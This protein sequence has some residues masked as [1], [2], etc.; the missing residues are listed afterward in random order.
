MAWPQDS[1]AD[2]LC[3]L[4]DT[5]EYAPSPV[6]GFLKVLGNGASGT[7]WLLG[8]VGGTVG[9]DAAAAAACARTAGSAGGEACCGG[10]IVCGSGELGNR[11]R[12]DR[13]CADER[14]ASRAPGSSAL[15]LGGGSWT[16]GGRFALKVSSRDEG[17]EAT[18]S[19]PRTEAELITRSRHDFIVRSFGSHFDVRNG[20]TYLMTEACMGGDLGSLLARLRRAQEGCPPPGGCRRRG[21]LPDEVAR[22]YAVCVVS[23]IGYLHEQGVMYR[24]LK[25]DNLLI[26]RGGHI[27]LTDFGLVKSLTQLRL[28]YFTRG[29]HADAATLPSAADTDRGDRGER[30]RP[31]PPQQPPPNA[32]DR[33]GQQERQA[34]YYRN[35]AVLWSTVGTPDYMAPEV[36]LETGYSQDCD[37][38][39][40]GVILYEMLVGY[41]PFYGDDPMVTCRKILC[42]QTVL[43]FPPEAGLSAEAVSLI[44]ALLSDRECRLGRRG[45][46]E[47]KAHP[48]FAKIDWSRLRE[49]GAAPFV[50]TVTSATDT[51]N[52]DSFEEPGG[53]TR[54]GPTTTRPSHVHAVPVRSRGRTRRPRSRRGARRT[55]PSSAASTAATPPPPSPSTAARRAPRRAP[56]ALPSPLLAAHPPQQTSPPRRR[57]CS[58]PT[59][60]GAARCRRQRR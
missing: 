5:D 6:A 30:G 31:P 53:R 11:C 60:P 4:E 25:P 17:G 59:P 20:K 45:A 42:F 32:W 36:L 54:H 37:W 46:D 34:A 27:K 50:P 15:A 44:R 9:G 35:R 40:L 12:G 23:A 1:P 48:F 14:S 38:W 7:V 2:P 22:T 49:P 18:C 41:P 16:H 21:R 55:S 47:I 26:D 29:A 51:A 39:S 13:C 8:T 28:R 43:A 52:F 57:P 24:D 10:C 3:L 58:C 56:P 19:D 33:M